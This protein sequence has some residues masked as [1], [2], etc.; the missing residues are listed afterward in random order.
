[1]SNPMQNSA[2]NFPATTE[3]QEIP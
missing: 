1:M 3:N 2:D